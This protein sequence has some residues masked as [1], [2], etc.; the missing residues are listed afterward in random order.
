M[1]VVLGFF[2]LC[3]FDVG[4]VGVVVDCWRVGVDCVDLGVGYVVD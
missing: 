2:V 3:W 4:D 1:V